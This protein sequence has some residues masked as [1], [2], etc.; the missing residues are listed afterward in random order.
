[1][2]LQGAE[3]ITSSYLAASGEAGGGHRHLSAREVCWLVDHCTQLS[4]LRLELLR[5]LQ[6]ELP[7]SGAQDEVAELKELLTN[8]II[9]QTRLA[10]REGKLGELLRRMAD[11]QVLDVVAVDE[12]GL[13]SAIQ[14]ILDAAA[15]IRAVAGDKT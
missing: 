11:T 4:R 5:A 13:R 8:L 3:S 2:N 1:M 15:H 7:R 9:M 6:A 12:A 10:E 14:G